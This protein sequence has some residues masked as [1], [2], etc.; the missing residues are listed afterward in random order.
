MVSA[1]EDIDNLS[2]QAVSQTQT[3]SASTEEQ[4]AS[5]EEIAASSQ[6][7]ASMAEELRQEV[8]KFQLA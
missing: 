5:T 8:G 2:K 6:A 7:L 4:A 1:M 3:V